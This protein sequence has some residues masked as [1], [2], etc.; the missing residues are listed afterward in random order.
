MPADLRIV[1][2]GPPA[3]Y[4]RGEPFTLNRRGQR[5]LLFFLACQRGPVSRS[6]LAALFWGDQPERKAREKLRVALSRLKAVLPFADML[7][8]EQGQVLLD[9]VHYSCDARDFEVLYEESAR[10]LAQIPT[11]TP[12]PEAV[13]KRMQEAVDLWRGSRFLAGANLGDSSVLDD[14]MMDTGERLLRQ[15]QRLLERLADHAEAAGDLD[16]STAWRK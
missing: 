3:I 16:A 11:S 15:R 9:P 7:H 10:T 2:L 6:E 13:R 1:L 5:A 14:W 12:L 8:T 4:L